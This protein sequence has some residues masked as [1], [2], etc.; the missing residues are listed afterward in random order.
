[1]KRKVKVKDSNKNWTIITKGGKIISAHHCCNLGKPTNYVCRQVNIVKE[2][3]T[4]H[5]EVQAIAKIKK[6]LL[7]T[8]K[9]NDIKIIN[10][11]LSANGEIKNAKSCLACTKVLHRLGITNIIYSNDDGNFVK[12]KIIDVL[13]HAKYSKYS[14]KLVEN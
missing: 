3:A 6:T 9:I 1:V 7:K 2:Y 4:R 14:R 8:R 13:N 5:S 11:R 12:D 10:F